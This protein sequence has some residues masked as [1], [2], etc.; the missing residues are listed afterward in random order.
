MKYHSIII[1][2]VLVTQ[3]IAYA[4]DISFNT[5]INCTNGC[6]FS[7]R[8]N[9]VGGVKP[10]QNDNVIIDMSS[11]EFA[12]TIIIMT[13][14]SQLNF[15]SLNV[16]CNDW[17]KT[18]LLTTTPD[19]YLQTFN[20]VVNGTVS[21]SIHSFAEFTVDSTLDIGAYSSISVGGDLTSNITNADAYSTITLYSGAQFST[22]TI[23]Y[24]NGLIDGPSD[25]LVEIDGYVSVQG[26]INVGMFT[27]ETASVTH[28]GTLNV[29]IMSPVGNL[30]IS[31]GGLVTV[32]QVLTASSIIVVGSSTFN[33]SGPTTT[34]SAIE[35]VYTDS[36][37]TVYISS[38]Q[39]TTLLRNVESYGTIT[40]NG[41]SASISNGIIAYLNLVL[42]PDSAEQQPITTI[43]NT[44]VGVVV[45]DTDVFDS[46][47][48]ISLNCVDYCELSEIQPPAYNLQ[49]GVS[50]PGGF[51]NLTKSDISLAGGGSRITASSKST[52]I[53][54]N[55]MVDTN[56]NSIYVDTNSQVLIQNSNING[57]F[58]VDHSTITV[59]GQSSVNNIEMT[60]SVLN[61][62][63]G[64]LT[65][66]TDLLVTQGSTINVILQSLI[67]NPTNTP[68]NVH[69][70]D[71]S[72]SQ[73]NLVVQSSANTI[74]DPDTLYYVM[75]SPKYIDVPFSN[76]TFTPIQSSLTTPNFTESLYN[77]Y[78]YLI[79]D[80]QTNN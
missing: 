6:S 75:A 57:P 30:T 13:G 3:S 47:S 70:Q 39:G 34:Y 46:S 78:V 60:A 29:G 56:S 45:C 58:L 21:I 4:S 62:V 49:I 17:S 41:V 14:P 9:W 67:V 10:G 61:V 32:G 26:S 42:K 72:I 68:I 40:I 25:S 53:F 15:R 80:F 44:K 73:S 51:L 38:D 12:S 11:S 5:N 8:D 66:T 52:I 55:T 76:C 23:A 16:I 31:S 65:I 22:L 37:S 43:Q 71:V 64:V 35:A 36:T 27:F 33:I 54:N 20:L 1:I 77:D 7:D 63:Q 18:L 50:S 59:H 74:A 19:I 28:P 69:G 2:F 24:L 48:Y 79:F